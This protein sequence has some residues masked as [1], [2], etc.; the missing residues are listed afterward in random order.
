MSSAWTAGFFPSWE[1]ELIRSPFQE[2]TYSRFDSPQVCLHI[3]SPS[4]TQI[5]QQERGVNAASSSL[6]AAGLRF[7]TGKNTRRS[8]GS[9]S[10]GENF[11]GFLAGMGDSAH[12][13]SSPLFGHAGEDFGVGRSTVSLCKMLAVSY[14]KSPSKSTVKFPLFTFQFRKSRGNRVRTSL[15]WLIAIYTTDFMGI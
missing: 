9:P 4:L 7:H 15:Q 12:V 10:P 13:N 6:P 1:A 3:F 5:L 8:P 2:P 11:V 14:R